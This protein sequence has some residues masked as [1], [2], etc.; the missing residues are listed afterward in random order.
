M[1]S[2]S[3]KNEIRVVK[4]PEKLENKSN[5]TTKTSEMEN[6]MGTNLPMYQNT[7]A[8]IS[9]FFRCENFKCFEKFIKHKTVLCPEND[10]M[11]APGF[12]LINHQSSFF[13]YFGT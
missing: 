3:D 13:L 7:L 10:F 2:V 5:R 8:K 6:S 1:K 12:H 11:C 9:L 4:F